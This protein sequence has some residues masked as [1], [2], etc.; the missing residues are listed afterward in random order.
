MTTALPELGLGILLAASMSPEAIMRLFK[1]DIHAAN[2]FKEQA[3]CD[4]GA[5]QHQINVARKIS[6]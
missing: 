6:N 2:A 3:R 5:L 4:L 1:C